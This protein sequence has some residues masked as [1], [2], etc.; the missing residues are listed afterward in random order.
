MKLTPATV[1]IE[2]AVER[3]GI[4]PVLEAVGQV[5]RRVNLDPWRMQLQACAEILRT[6]E[7][8]VNRAKNAEKKETHRAS[9]ISISSK[10]EK[11]P[12]S[13]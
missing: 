2:D 1:A 3:Y 13:A 9:P 10:A 7:V 12:H 4:R 5:C 8:K 11:H 6:E